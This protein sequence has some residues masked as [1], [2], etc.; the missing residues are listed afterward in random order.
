MNSP[1]GTQRRARVVIADDHLLTR[2]GLRAVLE[3]DL[4]FEVVGEATNGAE[5]L[6][7][8]RRVQP[9][10]VLMDVR[11]PNMNGLEATAAIRHANPSTIV[12]I[13]SMFEDSQ[14]LLAAM[15]AGAAG[16]ILKGSTQVSL[17][18]AMSDALA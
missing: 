1:D 9:D 10:L 6:A 16:Y 8:T 14:L 5:V 12:L 17:R 11:M 7:L 15:R 3:N 4:Q 2:A 13:L 18:T